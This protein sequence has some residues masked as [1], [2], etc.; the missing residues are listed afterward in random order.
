[1]FSLRF[2]ACGVPVRSCITCIR[3]GTGLQERIS[4]RVKCIAESTIRLAVQRTCD[5]GYVTCNELDELYGIQ[6]PPQR[7]SDSGPHS[8]CDYIWSAVARAK[9]ARLLD[10][11]VEAPVPLNRDGDI[12]YLRESRLC[13]TYWYGPNCARVCK[14]FTFPPSAFYGG[15]SKIFPLHRPLQRS[16][17]K[18]IT[19]RST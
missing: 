18:E 7:S 9:H 15:D 4:G 3:M 13:G 6:N 10:M 11:M 14:A 19:L 16:E 5:D 17:R 1:M 8:M 2:C 12:L